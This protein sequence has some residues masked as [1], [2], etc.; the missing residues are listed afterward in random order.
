[1]GSSQSKSNSS[2]R[3]SPNQEKHNSADSKAPLAE[4]AA[5]FSLPDRVS[6][7]NYP[8]INDKSALSPRIRTTDVADGKRTRSVPT[9]RTSR[10]TNIDVLEGHSD[11]S[12]P[13]P[14][15]R[16]HHLSELIDPTELHIDSHIRSPSGHLL[17]PEQF[18]VH[19]DRPKSIRERQEEIREKVRAASRLGLERTSAE[20]TMPSKER[21]GSPEKSEKVKKGKKRICCGLGRFGG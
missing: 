9:P 19:P 4:H 17:A 16:I 2:N 21:M 8:P 5:K 3:S 15:P 12:R 14:P 1:M 18:L 20:H 11:A 7:D 6:E 13:P 10:S